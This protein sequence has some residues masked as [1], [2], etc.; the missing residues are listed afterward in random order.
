MVIAS[1][2]SRVIS[3][4]I[5]TNFTLKRFWA[6]MRIAAAALIL[7]GF[8]LSVP[9]WASDDASKNTGVPYSWASKRM[10]GEMWGMARE[11]VD[12]DGMYEILLLKR[13]QLIVGRI[14]GR[15][16]KRKFSCEW[17]GSAKAARLD[18]F[19]LDGDGLKEAIITAADDGIPASLA[20]KIEGKGCKQ[21]LSDVAL[22]LRVMW[23]P[24]KDEE[25]GWRESIVGQGWSSQQYFSGPVEEYRFEKGKLKRVGRV[26]LPRNTRVYRFA[27][28]PPEDERDV[29]VLYRSAAPL[30]VRV[31]V[32][33]NKWKKTWRSP[34]RYGS[35][36]NILKAVQRPALDRVQ[37]DYASFELPPLVLRNIYGS[38]ILMV[39]Y[40]MPI[41]NIVG[42]Q[43][44]IR[45]SRVYD[46]RPD[47]A[48]VFA[49]KMQTQHMPGGVVDYLAAES[50]TGRQLWVLVQDNRGAFENPTESMILRFDLGPVAMP[51]PIAEPVQVEEPAKIEKPDRH[52]DPAQAQA[53]ESAKA[54]EPAKVEESAKVEE[55]AKAEVPAQVEEPAQHEEPAEKA[56][57]KTE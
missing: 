24:P 18:L 26:R 23:L 57:A 25:T 19:D 11:D 7:T 29:V 36:G 31:N 48:F 52:K 51:V 5:M 20:L 38:D 21:V 35:S 27:F 50:R 41:H 12:G 47:E 28:L 37:S 32:R 13:E 3:A 10:D 8:V 17:K 54:E 42:R 16:F 53:E 1:T 55:P 40:D 4:L 9:A 2:S 14:D 33:G 44:Y 22:S 49:E 30:E 45:G 34:Q 56:S 15:K 6:G 46:Y 39:K 43:P